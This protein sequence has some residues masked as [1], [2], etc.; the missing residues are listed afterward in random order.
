MRTKYLIIFSCVIFINC[1]N[2]TSNQYY[3]SKHTYALDSLD[4]ELLMLKNQAFC[5]CYNEALKGAEAKLFPA[6]GSNYIQIS[7]LA[8]KYSNDPEL[9]K[10][11]KSWNKKDYFSYSNDNKLY[12]MRCL[13]FY[14]SKELENYI[15][16]IRAIELTEWIK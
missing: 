1:I 2:S 9:D 12:L 8:T 16:S 3:N 10:L 11:I 7:E 6:D 15:D 13:D 14:N 4:I 5:N